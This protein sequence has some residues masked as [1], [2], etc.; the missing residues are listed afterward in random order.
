MGSGR[1][2]L[3]LVPITSWEQRDEIDS[4]AHLFLL[5]TAMLRSP[6]PLPAVALGELAFLCSWSD[7]EKERFYDSFAEALDETLRTHDPAPAREFLRLMASPDP[8]SSGPSI[9]GLISEASA[10][11]A[12]QRFGLRR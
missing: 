2:N 10:T 1:E 11:S 4:L 12:K 9:S 8:V 6:T 7:E 3:L 5:A